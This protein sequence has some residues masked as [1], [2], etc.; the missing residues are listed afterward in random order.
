MTV[1]L[2]PDVLH[3][4]RRFSLYNSPYVAHEDGRAIDLYPEGNVAPSPVSGEVLDV[5]TVEAPPKPY[6]PDHDHLTLVDAGSH[7]ARLLHVEPTVKPGEFVQ[8]G[9]PLGETIRAGFFAPWVD[10]HV[11]LEFRGPERDPY[12]ASGSVPIAVDVTVEPLEWDGTGTVVET[13]ETYAVLDAPT[14]P[15]PGA[16]FVGVGVDGDDGVLDGGLSHYDGGGVLAPSDG[17]DGRT[18][19]KLAGTSVG[20]RD[21]DGR[22]VEWDVRQVR[23]NG[24]PITG[25]SLFLARDDGFGV[26]LVCPDATF[27]VGEDVTV[28]LRR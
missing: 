27:E 5:T 13:G 17:S 11:H 18:D 2:G 3:R 19:P 8:R 1:T 14:H 4:Y 10:D 16:H 15:D 25:I 12:R 21:G 24:E 23:A 20:R 7:V 26:K 6:A 28:E 9:D 22:T